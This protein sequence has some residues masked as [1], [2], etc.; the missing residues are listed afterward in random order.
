[1]VQKQAAGQDATSLTIPVVEQKGDHHWSSLVK[2][3][4]GTAAR[5]CHLDSSMGCGSKVVRRAS[6]LRQGQPQSQSSLT[7]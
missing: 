5:H 7:G 3:T 6:S 2:L 1:M 4:V